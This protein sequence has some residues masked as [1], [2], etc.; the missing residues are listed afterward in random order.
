MQ[1]K[2]WYNKWDL[3]MDRLFLSVQNVVLLSLTELII[4]LFVKGDFDRIKLIFVNVTGQCTDYI[5]LQ[6]QMYQENGSSLSMG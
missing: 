1:R 3:E 6:L 2:K 5:V 4:A